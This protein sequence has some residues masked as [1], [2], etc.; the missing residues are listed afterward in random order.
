[1]MEASDRLKIQNHKNKVL[2][3]ISHLGRTRSVLELST[4]ASDSFPVCPSLQMPGITSQPT[5][6]IWLLMLLGE[7]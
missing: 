2:K 5:L 1:M 7:D 3:L 4:L 6:Y